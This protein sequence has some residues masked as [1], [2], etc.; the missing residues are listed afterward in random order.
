MSKKDKKKPSGAREPWEQSIYDT[1]KNSGGSRSEKRQQKKG[2]TVFL[3]ILVILL[4]LIITLPVGT[5]LY[6]MRDKPNDNKETSKP[7]SSVVVQSSTKNSSTQPSSQASTSASSESVAEG[8]SSVIQET[9]PTSEVAEAY[10]EVLNGEGPNQVA[11][12]NGI[13][14]EELLQLNGL[15]MDSMLQPGQSLRIK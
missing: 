1:D 14:T 13:T 5:Y 15:S 10:T 7:S 6:V 9:T 11:A 2:N 4:L 3:T 12:R 8:Q